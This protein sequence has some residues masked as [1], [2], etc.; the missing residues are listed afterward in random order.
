MFVKA[1]LKPV[2]GKAGVALAKILEVQEVHHVAGE[3]CYFVKVR[4][5]DTDDLSR[6][7]QQQISTFKS[8]RSTRTTIVLSTVKETARLSLTGFSK[9]LSEEPE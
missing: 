3:D 2:T 9:G 8:V 4:V 6:L 5:C 7:L 1:K